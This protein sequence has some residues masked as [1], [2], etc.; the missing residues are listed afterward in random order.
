MPPK[1]KPLAPEE[2]DTQIKN[3]SD[4]A[5][6]KEAIKDLKDLNPLASSV[7]D[8][9]S[10]I[11]DYESTGCLVLDAMLSGR[12]IG[13]G[14]PE[15]RVNI[16]AA[17]SSTGK[18]YIALR[19]AAIAQRKGKIVVIFDSEGAIDASICQSVGLDIDKVIYYPVKSVEDCAIAAYKVLNN[20]IEKKLYNKFFMVI[21]SLGMMSSELQWERLKKEN[22]SADMSFAK[23]MG[24]FMKQLCNLSMASKTTCLCTNH[25][26]DSVS[27]YPSVEK[28]Q[29]G[30]KKTKF[31]PT[32]VV[33]LNARTVK[34]DDNDVKVGESAAI[35]G[36]D[37]VGI[38]INAVCIKSRVC[39]P[40]I[41]AGLFLSWRKGLSKW[42]GILHLAEE[43][44]V[45][46]SKAGRVYI[47]EE[48]KGTKRELM[49]N[50][51]FLTSIIPQLQEK[52]NEEWTYKDISDD[53]ID[54]DD[55][56][57]LV[58]AAANA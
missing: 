57:D 2:L 53:D 29:T 33:Q 47:G 30:G 34:S 38:A 40:R 42:Y 16:L 43:F 23:S 48:C 28:N 11:N 36:D 35:G 9:H 7:R 51:E 58:D 14:F 27:L 5:L 55:E 26:Y 52:I 50:K 21:D 1:K 56:S 8:A 32:T 15:G 17:E 3:P 39:R 10:N 13:G 41:R 49:L 45:I 31:V 44:G 22:T 12:I 25:V 20:V 24:Q 4:A 6:M 18:T 19:T 46:T 54:D 37:A